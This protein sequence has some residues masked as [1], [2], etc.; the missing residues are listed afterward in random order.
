MTMIMTESHNALHLG[1]CVCVCVHECP[2][3]YLCACVRVC[4]AVNT[5]NFN[6]NNHFLDKYKSGL[7]F[8]NDMNY[9]TMTYFFLI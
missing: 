2:C 1:M 7:L 9:H 3:V 6:F 5:V 8:H 4:V